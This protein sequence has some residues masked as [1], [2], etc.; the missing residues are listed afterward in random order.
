MYVNEWVRM[1]G[2]DEISQGFFRAELCGKL[3]IEVEVLCHERERN[4]VWCHAH[5]IA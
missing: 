2:G 5:K 4:N 1:N 3:L